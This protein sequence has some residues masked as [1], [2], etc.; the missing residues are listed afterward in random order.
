MLGQIKISLNDGSLFHEML[1]EY[2]LLLVQL[3]YGIIA[4]IDILLLQMLDVME[5]Y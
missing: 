2:S 5:G 1:L 4:Y 3:L